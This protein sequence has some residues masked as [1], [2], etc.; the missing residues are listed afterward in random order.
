[1]RKIIASAGIVLA[2][3]ATTSFACDMG[4]ADNM[5]KKG[6]VF[7]PQKGDCQDVTT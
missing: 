5:C 6:Q 1:M 3:G 4:E 2:I 7:A